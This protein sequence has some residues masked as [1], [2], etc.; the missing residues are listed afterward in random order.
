MHTEIW[1]VTFVQ[2]DHLHA[3]TAEAVIIKYLTF[4]GPCIV[5]I[6]IY[7]SNKMQI[8]QFI[9]LWKLLYMF[10]GVFPPETCRAVSRDKLC[11]FVSCWIYNW[12]IKQLLVLLAELTLLELQCNGRLECFVFAALRIK[13]SD[14]WWPHSRADLVRTLAVLLSSPARQRG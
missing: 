4:R 2:N 3:R 7:I 8:T 12:I 5:S 14:N 9:Y 10:R 13:M 1:W 6:F 11:N